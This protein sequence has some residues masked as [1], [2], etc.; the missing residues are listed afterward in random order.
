MNWRLSS[1][2][3]ICKRKGR[4]HYRSCWAASR[5]V[6]RSQRKRNKTASWRTYSSYVQAPWGAG[7]LFSGGHISG[8][9]QRENDGVIWV[10][11]IFCL[12]QFLWGFPKQLNSVSLAFLPSGD[13]CVSIVFF[14]Y[15]AKWSTTNWQSKVTAKRST[16]SENNVPVPSLLLPMVK[17]QFAS[18]L[19]L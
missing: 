14:F 2:I 1:L 11:I 10:S 8:P 9:S 18:Y 17:M 15:V 3:N 16:D 12:S 19:Y 5:R 6:R 4:I 13:V 7:C